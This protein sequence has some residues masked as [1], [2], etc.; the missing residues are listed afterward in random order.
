MLERSRRVELALECALGL[1]LGA[2][3]E[4]GVNAQARP[5]EILL[6][7]VAAQR[8]THEVE[9]RRV[10][11]PGGAARDAERGARR[12]GR[13]GRRDDPLIG[14]DFQHQVA[15]R[16]GALGVAA[17]IVVRRP[18]HDRDQQRYLREVELRERLAE[19]ELAREP[20]AV[21]GAVAVLP[22]EDLIDIGVHEIGLGEMR[23]ERHR[24]D[25]LTQLPREGLAGAEEVAAHQLLR[26]GAAALLDLAGAHVDPRRA[27]HR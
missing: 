27:Q 14:H 13:L 26:E 25:R 18:A 12:G 4:A 8:A 22:E 6:V 9:V 2:R 11:G 23:I 20:E 3:V 19:V 5:G 24:H 10:V 21:D 7:V 16:A 1:I 15:A 17:R